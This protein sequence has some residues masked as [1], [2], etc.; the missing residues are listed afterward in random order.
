MFKTTVQKTNQQSSLLRRVSFYWNRLRKEK[1]TKVVAASVASLAL[2][3][4]LTAGVLPIGGDTAMAAGDD[5]IVRNGVTSKA[6]M[7]AVYDRNSDGAGHN[8]IK[9]IYTHFGVTRQDIANTTMGSYKSNDFNGQLKTI[10]R[11]NFTNS[12]RSAVKVN[13]TTTIYTG[14]FLNGDNNRPVVQKALI[15]KR[16]VDGKWFAITL[17]CGNL[18]YVDMPPKPKPPVTPAAVCTSLTITS[19]TRNSVK[20]SAR[21][22]VSGGAKISAYR[23]VITKDGGSQVLDR[24]IP[25]TGTSSSINFT[26]PSDGTYTAKLTVQT[27]AGAKT[28]DAC[29]KSFTVKPAP[30][31]EVGVKKIEVCVLE[32]KE[33]DMINEVEFDE[34]LHSRDDS[35]C[36]EVVETPRN[37]EVCVTETGELDTIREDEFDD[38]LH[39]MTLADCDD[40]TPV[41]PAPVQELPRTGLGENI[42]SVFG[43]GSVIASVG[44]YVASRRGLLS[45]MLNR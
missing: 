13:S 5:N 19:L 29:T 27:S 41:T 45:A 34:N 38:S 15:G 8:D 30:V 36:E 9:A 25:T 31:K 26:A 23:Y 7:L 20:L 17:D 37:I 32:T 2:V 14:P 11:S 24:S 21:A 16:A 10:G 4:Q 18:V 43:L 35:D 28:A 33:M 44:Y 39:S 6:D 40:E 22:S 3:L 42:V 1:V 12:G